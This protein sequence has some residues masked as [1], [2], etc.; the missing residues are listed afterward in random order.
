MKNWCFNNWSGQITIFH[1][2][3]FPWNSRGPISLPKR[4]LLGVPS[5]V[6][7]RDFIWPDW[8]HIPSIHLRFWHFKLT[9]WHHQDVK[10]LPVLLQDLSRVTRDW[11][12]CT[13]SHGSNG[14]SEALY[15]LLICWKVLVFLKNMLNVSK[16]SSGNYGSLNDLITVA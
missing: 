8:W 16:N 13:F 6:W 10:N 5:V 11:W 9:R 14:R 1:Q 7:G 3:R 15:G 2:A 12:D 4:Y